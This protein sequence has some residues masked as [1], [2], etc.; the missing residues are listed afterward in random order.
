MQHI[1]RL[2][3]DTIDGAPGGRK[4]GSGEKLATAWGERKR[5]AAPRGVI[6]RPAGVRRGV[7]VARGGP[8]RGVRAQQCP[9]TAPLASRQS[10]AD[11]ACACVTRAAPCTALVP[12][13]RRAP[14]RCGRERDLLRYRRNISPNLRATCYVL[15]FGRL[16]PLPGLFTPHHVSVTFILLNCDMISSN[17]ELASKCAPWKFVIKASAFLAVVH[18]MHQFTIVFVVCGRSWIAGDFR[19]STVKVSNNRSDGHV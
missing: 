17:S 10:P 18:R 1:D 16:H 3:L 5:R 6:R 8:G 12:R 4:C 2:K 15:T 11:S 19:N 13:S 9:R 14:P 7:R